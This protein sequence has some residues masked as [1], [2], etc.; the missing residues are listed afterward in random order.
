ML[1][2]RIWKDIS[3][4]VDYS[5]YEIKDYVVSADGSS[6]YYK[7]SPWGRRKINLDKVIK[8]G[9]EVELNGHIIDPLSFYVSYAYNYWRYRGPSTGPAGVAGEKLGDRAKNRV[10]A[11]LRYNLFEKTLLLLD[12]KFQD[13]QIAEVC[14]ENPPGSDF[15]D[16][17]DNQ[18]AASHVFDFAIEQTLVKKYGFIK[19]AVLKVY[20]NNLFD[21]EYENSRGYPMTDCICG[22]ALSFSF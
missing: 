10:N 7:N 1:T 2:R 19:D 17:Y 3:L 15:W 4:K 20:V 6:D 8:E 12:Y 18:M 16:C 13:E 11:G 21:E 5:H 14:E 9:V 22:A